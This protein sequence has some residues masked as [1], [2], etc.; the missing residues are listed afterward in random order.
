MF[1]W[2]IGVAA[3]V[4][5]CAVAHA[6][7]EP[8]RLVTLGRPRPLSAGPI[9]QSDPPPPP[10]SDPSLPADSGLQPAAFE[11]SPSPATQVFA[12]PYDSAPPFNPPGIGSSSSESAF[13]GSPVD[14]GFVGGYRESAKRPPERSSRH[15]SFFETFG[16]IFEPGTG[17][18]SNWREWFRS[19]HCFDYFISPMTNPFLFEDPRSLTE[20]RP[21]FM[22]QHIP[23]TNPAFRGGNAEFFGTQLR[24]A[25]TER[26]SFTMNK[27]GWTAINTG[28]GS[29]EPGGV[30]FSEVQLGPKFTFLRSEDRRMLGAAGVIFQIPAGRGSVYQDTGSLSIVPYFSFAKNFAETQFGSLNFMN[31]TGYSFAADHE[32]TD[33]FYTSFHL[34]WDVANLHRYYPLLELHWFQ[35]MR[36]GGVRPVSTEGR[37]LANIGS[38][39]VGGRA[40]FHGAVG[41]RYKFSEAAQVGFGFEFPLS[42]RRDLLD[43]RFTVDFIWRY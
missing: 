18:E 15:R 31:T 25:V 2:P 34:D 6:Q 29:T 13:S 9:E 11:P 30:G 10:L 17:Q 21:I 35:Y 40:N 4:L 1:R 12:A 36:S 37:D 26:F 28:S 43:Y 27:L 23:N 24:L 16:E 20:V 19:D 32:R 42:G 7:D 33:F 5:V 38:T 39:D 41:M 22:I 14:P 8:R 3:I